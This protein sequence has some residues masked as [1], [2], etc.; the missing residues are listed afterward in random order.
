MSQALK[1]IVRVRMDEG[2]GERL[3][4]YKSDILLNLKMGGMWKTPLFF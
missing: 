1:L 2:P 4:S 3:K